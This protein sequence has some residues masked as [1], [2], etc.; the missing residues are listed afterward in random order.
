MTFVYLSSRESGHGSWRSQTIRV[1]KYEVRECAGDQMAVIQL[2]GSRKRDL[3]GFVVR[4]VLPA[5]T[6]QMVGPFIFFDHLGP[7]SISTGLRHR[8]QTPSAHCTRDRYLPFCGSLVHRDSLGST[9]KKSSPG[10]VNWMTC[11]RGHRA[12]RTDAPRSLAAGSSCSRHP[13]LGGACRTAWRRSK[14][15]LRP[16][17]AGRLPQRVLKLGEATL[18]VIAGES[19]GLRIAG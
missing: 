19:F 9:C 18:A 6:R 3:G 11:G 14:A 2:I 12:L 5:E 7:G 16:L 15:R 8:R 4:R 1:R 13:E 17:P 10:D